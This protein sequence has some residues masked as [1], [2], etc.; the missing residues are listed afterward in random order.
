MPTCGGTDVQV[1][2]H[3]VA[4]VADSA[5]VL[6]ERDLVADRDRGAAGIHMRK[7]DAMPFAKQGYLVTAFRYCGCKLQMRM[8][9]AAQ[10]IGAWPLLVP[11]AQ[12]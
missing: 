4:G 6:T 1:R 2:L 12:K 7:V 5:E 9:A 11:V 3:R 8:E 10:T